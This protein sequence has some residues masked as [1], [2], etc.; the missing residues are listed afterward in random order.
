MTGWSEAM[1]SQTTTPSG[2]L[3]TTVRQASA[4]QLFIVFRSSSTRIQFQRRSRRASLEPLLCTL[5]LRAIPELLGAQGAAPMESHETQ[6]RSRLGL[7]MEAIQQFQHRGA[8][9]AH[10]QHVATRRQR[11]R[12]PGHYIPERRRGP[13]HRQVVG[14]HYPLETYLS[15]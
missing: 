3:S 11:P 8:L 6:T 10:R 5:P 13:S 2:A 4:D 1:A 15:A 14:E 7:H 12:R 9:I